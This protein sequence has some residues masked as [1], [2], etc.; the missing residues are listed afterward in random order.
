MRRPE[1]QDVIEQPV[2]DRPIDTTA[3][4]NASSRDLL[5]VYG[6]STQFVTSFDGLRSFPAFAEIVRR[7]PNMLPTIA[8]FLVRNPQHVGLALAFENIQ[9]E[10][11]K[12]ESVAVQQVTKG[13]RE[14]GDKTKAI[15]DWA[16]AESHIAIRDRG[17]RSRIGWDLYEA[18]RI[19]VTAHLTPEQLDMLRHPHS[20]KLLGNT[21]TDVHIPDV[22]LPNGRELA[23]TQSTRFNHGE[24]TGRSIHLS[25][26]LNPNG[27]RIRVDLI[28]GPYNR[29]QDASFAFRGTLESTFNTANTIR[30]TVNE[31]FG[32]QIRKR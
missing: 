6:N 32:T 1:A 14:L 7:G 19:G 2:L 31:L 12:D 11:A 16:E 24:M 21:T 18:L 23:F 29:Q 30:G 26:N 5:Q 17:M 9:A 27:F 8:R 3:Y 20:F 10:Q 4:R 28:S 13:V 15:G 25:D 22:V